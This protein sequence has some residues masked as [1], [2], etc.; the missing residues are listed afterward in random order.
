[1]KQAAIFESEA[2]MAEIM[3]RYLEDRGYQT[4]AEVQTRFGRFDIVSVINDRCLIVETKLTNQLYV[5][6]QAIKAKKRSH[7]TAICMPSTTNWLTDIVQ[8]CHLLGIGIYTVE[9]GKHHRDAVTCMLPA[10]WRQV[11][12]DIIGELIPAQKDNVAGKPSAGGVVTAKSKWA[13][14]IRKYLAKHQGVTHDE[15]VAAMSD[16]TPYPTRGIARSA[17]VR[18][19]RSSRGRFYV[20][21]TADGYRIFT[22]EDNLPFG[23]FKQ[24]TESTK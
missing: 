16:R 23:K 14:E 8:R 13:A 9:P 20:K 17:L 6:H 22:N 18:I 3:R 24:D 7:Q 5:L 2:E 1:M 12:N 4:F 15:V 21:M 10:R 11:C 19:I